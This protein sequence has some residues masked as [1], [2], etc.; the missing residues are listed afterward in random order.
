MASDDDFEVGRDGASARR[1]SEGGSREG[2]D[3]SDQEDSADQF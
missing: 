1:F 2:A 3:G